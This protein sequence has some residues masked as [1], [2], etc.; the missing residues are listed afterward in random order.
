MKTKMMNTASYPPPPPPPSQPTAKMDARKMLILVFLIVIVV[1]SAAVL[2]FLATNK[3]SSTNPTPTPATTPTS[4]G[5]TATPGGLV[6][7]TPS[8]TGLT[9]NF[10]AG[11]W[12]QYVIK[13]YSPSGEVVTQSSMKYSVSEGSYNGV[14]CWLL[15]VETVMNE[16][17]GTV[18][19]VMTY[20]MNK[21]T[22]KGIHSK[23]ETFVNDEL[24]NV[25]EEDIT[26]DE[27]DVPKP[28][29]LSTVITYETITV[30]AGTFNCG[31]I[32]LQFTAGGKT[33][34]TNTWASKDVPV[35]GLVKQETRQDGVL[36]SITELTAYGG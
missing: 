6:T 21:N 25:V 1:V 7:P 32:T 14:D 34:V 26:P 5:S 23:T 15:K 30:P 3:P 20:W 35:V 29:D 24:I 10:R 9:A 12:A 36:L 13:T 33:T 27:E 28:F 4:P 16:E 11:A 22:L 19:T 17:T 2:F 8:G 31:K 18:K